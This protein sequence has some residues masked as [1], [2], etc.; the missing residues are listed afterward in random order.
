MIIGLIC[1]LVFISV[2]YA[3]LSQTLTTNVT[4]KLTGSWKIYISS[5]TPVTNSTKAVST[6]AEVVDELNA[7]FGVKFSIPGD[8]MEYDVVVK[9]MET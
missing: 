8:Y 3:I 2:G 7:S 5:I 4:G 9:M 1:C 6:N